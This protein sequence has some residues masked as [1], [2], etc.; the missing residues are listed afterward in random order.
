MTDLLC[1][2]QQTCRKWKA[3]VQGSLRLQQALFFK[4]V[5][6]P[7]VHWVTPNPRSDRSRSGARGSWMALHDQDIYKPCP[8]IFEHPL[9]ERFERSGEDEAFFLDLWTSLNA[10][11]SWRNSLITQPPIESLILRQAVSKGVEWQ[12]TIYTTNG[13]WI[14]FGDLMAN[15]RSLVHFRMRFVEASDQWKFSYGYSTLMSLL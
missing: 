7:E 10:S 3:I 8:L 15:F 14:T 13:F 12:T 9:L 11:A 6:F 1:G 4:P 2:V 5:P